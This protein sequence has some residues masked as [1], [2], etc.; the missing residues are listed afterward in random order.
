M[1]LWPT[2]G[3]EKR[4]LSSNRSPWKLHPPLCHPSRSGGI[5]SSADF[6]WKCFSTGA[7]PD[8]LPRS[9]EQIRVCPFLLRK[10]R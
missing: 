3:D 5:C 4:P 8:F 9:T 7:H 2:H 10:S 6:S 1:G